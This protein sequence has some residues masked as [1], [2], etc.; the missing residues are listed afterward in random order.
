[1]SVGGATV[2]GT[3]PSGAGGAAVAARAVVPRMAAEARTAITGS[4]LDL[5]N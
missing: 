5:R 1:M 3:D 4:A 2:T